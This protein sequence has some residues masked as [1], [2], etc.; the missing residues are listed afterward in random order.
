MEQIDLPSVFAGLD[1]EAKFKLYRKLWQEAGTYAILTSFP[2]HLDLELSGLCNLRCECCF[3][4]GLLTQPLGLMKVELF[5]HILDQAI[6]QGLCA[7]KLQIRGESLLH[8]DFFDCVK[9]AKARGV[10][11]VQLTTNGTLL[12][13]DMGQKILHSG[14]D[15]IIFSVDDQHRQNYTQ[16]YRGQEYSVVE[17]AIKEFLMLREKMD[18]SKPWVRLKTS[19]PQ[20]DPESF[21]NARKR[22]IARFPEADIFIVSRLHNLRNDCDPYPDFQQY[23]DFA[24]CAHLMQR[25]AIFWNGEVTTCCMDYNNQFQL[26]KLASQTVEAIW[27]SSKMQ[28]FRKMHQEQRRNMMPLCQHCHACLKPKTDQVMVDTTKSHV[29]DYV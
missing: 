15:A 6:P 29:A 25:L 17:S 20:S 7:I 21:E 19:I 14:L 3:Q 5:Q 11:D 2:L 8:P 9:Y 1:Q 26:G 27:M 24:P 13:E 10:L 18:I 16:I 4:N 12:N 28:H 23:Y 22:M